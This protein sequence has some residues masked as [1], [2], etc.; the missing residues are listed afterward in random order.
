MA[1][2]ENISHNFT[3]IDGARTYTTVIQFV[4]GIVVD[5]SRNLV[6]SGSLDQIA[7][8]SLLESQYKNSVNT[9]GTSDGIND[10]LHP[11]DPDPN[12][13]RGT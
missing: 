11:I 10:P 7:S 5:S 8:Q 12:K 6:G 2:V 1:H 13:L 9:F 4:R 3:N